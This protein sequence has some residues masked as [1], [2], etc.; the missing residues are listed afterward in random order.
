V[1]RG[2]VFIRAAW[3]AA[4]LLTAGLDAVVWPQA[5]DSQKEEKKIEQIPDED[6]EVIENMELLKNL[7]LFDNEDIELLKD[8]D[9]LTANE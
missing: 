2:R 3:A 1:N 6:R 9:V 7:K 5:A 8:L 4:F